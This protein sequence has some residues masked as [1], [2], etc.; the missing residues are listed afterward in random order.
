[1]EDKNSKTDNKK[2]IKLYNHN[3]QNLVRDKN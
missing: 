1:M 2:L 3:I